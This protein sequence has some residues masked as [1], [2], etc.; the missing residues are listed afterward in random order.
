MCRRAPLP[1]HLRVLYAMGIAVS[2]PLPKKIQKN[3][4]AKNCAESGAGLLP[5]ASAGQHLAGGPDQPVSR[6]RRGPATPRGQ[7][8]DVQGAQPRPTRHGGSQAASAGVSQQITQSV[9]AA[10][11]QIGD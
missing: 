4:I 11:D 6:G 5:G 9:Y 3:R 7:P 10:V 1:A 8:I 2:T